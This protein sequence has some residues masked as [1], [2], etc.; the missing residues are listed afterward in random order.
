VI[1]SVTVD[2]SAIFIVPTLRITPPACF[3]CD[4]QAAEVTWLFVGVN[5]RAV[6]DGCA[7]RLVATIRAAASGVIG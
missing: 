2:E 4:R 6:C 1:T 3:L 7:G 5:G